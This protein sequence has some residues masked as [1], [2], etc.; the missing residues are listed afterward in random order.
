MISKSEAKQKSKSN[1]FLGENF[2]NPFFISHAVIENNNDVNIYKK[3]FKIARPLFRNEMEI[4]LLNRSK[5]TANIKVLKQIREANK[6]F[7]VEYLNI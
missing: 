3:H 6:N 2:G 1:F 5:N 7:K 4:F